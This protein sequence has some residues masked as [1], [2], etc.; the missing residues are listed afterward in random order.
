MKDK[1][2][3]RCPP[4]C[5]RRVQSCKRQVPA[6]VVAFG[7]AVEHTVLRIAKSFP[8]RVRLMPRFV[9]WARRWIKSKQL[10][11]Q[12]TDKDGVFVIC[13]QDVLKS[14]VNEQL[15]KSFYRPCGPGN[16][17]ADAEQVRRGLLKAGK[18]LNEINCS[19]AAEVTASAL[20]VSERSLCCSLL[21]TLKTHKEPV[22]ARL[23]HSSVRSCFNAIGGAINRILEPKLGVPLALFWGRGCG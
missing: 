17:E 23:I 8:A 10:A 13:R 14:L 9:V 7:R 2:D 21:C 12:P 1:V 4:L 3:V 6:S 18:L 5:K 15:N 22:T 19:W 20:T 11:A 16:L